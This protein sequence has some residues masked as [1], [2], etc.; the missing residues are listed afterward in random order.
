MICF[1]IDEIQYMKEDMEALVNALHR[2][3]QKGFPVI[4]YG[5]GLPKILSIL[6]EVKSYTE[7]LFKYEPIAELADD[8]A[9]KAIIEPATF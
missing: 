5:A 2:V 8:D 6:G 7:R 9:G 1:F 3:N 4:L